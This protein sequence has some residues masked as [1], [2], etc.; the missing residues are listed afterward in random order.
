M[1]ISRKYKPEKIPLQKFRE[2]VLQPFYHHKTKSMIASDEACLVLLPVSEGTE[3]DD[4]HSTTK[5]ELL[6]SRKGK[7]TG[8]CEL[9]LHDREVPKP[10]IDRGLE[11]VGALT[12]KYTI[13]LDVNRLKKMVDA[14][15]EERVSLTFFGDRK[16]IVVE[17]ENGAWGML[18]P[19]SPSESCLRYPIEKEVTKK[20]RRCPAVI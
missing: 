9:E 11:T 18:S 14:M 2:G 16:I 6:E 15:G 5:E 13:R 12:P 8:D 3:E 19:V 4:G 17:T 1:K 10:P 7:R 20:K